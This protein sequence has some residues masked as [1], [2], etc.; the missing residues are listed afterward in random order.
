MQMHFQ[1]GIA[2][3]EC[4][5]I[6][7]FPFDPGL[8]ALGSAVHFAAQRQRDNQEGRDGGRVEKWR[9]KLRA[10]QAVVIVEKYREVERKPVRG[11]RPIPQL[12]RDDVLRLHVRIAE[13]G[14]FRRPGQCRKRRIQAGISSCGLATRARNGGPE[15]SATARSPHQTG[16]WTTVE[17]AKIVVLEFRS[18]G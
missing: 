2:R 10:F 17:T 13:Q 18:Q 5:S 16:A 14:Q 8:D 9:K 1:K 15:R 11:L 12:V 7:W 3:A 4:P 6:C